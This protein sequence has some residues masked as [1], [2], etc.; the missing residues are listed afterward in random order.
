MKYSLKI[1]PLSII[2]LI[3]FLT[4]CSNPIE[5]SGVV[6]DENTKEPIEGV[7][8]DIS[9]KT[10]R[11]DSL[12]EKVFTDSNGYFHIK[13]KRDIGLFFTLEKSGYGYFT[14][15]LSTPNDTIEL[16]DVVPY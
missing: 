10:Q 16:G 7:Y 3:L 9:M 2:F 4:S 13:E 6:I 5:R 1:T 11:R 14:S 15:T 12:K 8:I